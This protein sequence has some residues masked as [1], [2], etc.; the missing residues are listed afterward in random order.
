MQYKGF[1]LPRERVLSYRQHWPQDMDEMLQY[2]GEGRFEPPPARERVLPDLHPPRPGPGG[3]S[4]SRTGPSS[5][6]AGRTCA[7]GHCRLPT[8]CS[9]PASSSSMTL[10]AAPCRASWAGPSCA[11][12]KTARA[13]KRRLRLLS[14]SGPPAPANS[15]KGDL[16]GRLRL[17][18]PANLVY[19]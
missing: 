12:R 9:I 1:V 8:P 2:R 18:A 11:R 16:I 19:F 13:R 10:R 3:S 15:S 6:C 7:S 17:D 5:P 14:C 4:T